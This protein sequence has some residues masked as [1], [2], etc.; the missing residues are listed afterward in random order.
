MGCRE[1]RAERTYLLSS[2]AFDP[3]TR[4]EAVTVSA[5]VN[6]CVFEYSEML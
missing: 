5:F 4:D 3:D 6:V 2:L 1:N